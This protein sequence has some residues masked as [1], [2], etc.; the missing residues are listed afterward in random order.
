MREKA[1]NNGRFKMGSL[2]L[3]IRLYSVASLSMRN[4]DTDLP[5]LLVRIIGWFWVHKNKV[6]KRIP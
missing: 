1:N 5:D 6:I 2:P 3:K 4:K